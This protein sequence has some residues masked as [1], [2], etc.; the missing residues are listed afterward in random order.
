MKI[1]SLL[2]LCLLPATSLINAHAIIFDLNGVLMYL[3]R[4]TALSKIGVTKFLQYSMTIDLF[5]AQKEV[6]KFLHSIKPIT[7]T[8]PGWYSDSEQLPQI[9]NDWHKGKLRSHDIKLLIKEHADTYYQEDDERKQV[10]LALTGI[11]FTPQ[12]LASAMMPCTEGIE[13]VRLCKL[14]G[15]KTYLLSN[16]DTETYEYLKEKYPWFWQLFDGIIISGV[17]ECAKPDPKIYK[18]T[19]EQ[20]DI[21]P[22]DAVFIDDIS[23]NVRSA[24][25]LGIFGIVCKQHRVCIEKMPYITYV[26][27]VLKLWWEAQ[28]YKK[29]FA[30]KKVIASLQHENN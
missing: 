27:D 5:N 30:L 9:I 2:L 26:R 16:L 20:F 29:Y 23:H 22:N 12:T 28:F 15:H 7:N 13:L 17:V 4:S 14:L 19:L 25:E 18:L 10:T 3:S 8:H 6:F 24:E 21:D 11:L 1:K